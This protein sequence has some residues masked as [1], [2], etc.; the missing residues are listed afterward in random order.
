MPAPIDRRSFLSHSLGV[1]AAA[2]VGLRVNAQS[3]GESV[4]RDYVLTARPST[5]FT[6]DGR[7]WETWTYNGQGPEVRKGEFRKL[8]N[9]RLNRRPS[10]GTAWMCPIPWTACPT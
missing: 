10:T 4:V 9:Q 8:D 1:A 5:V 2:A 6:A 7:P 3:P